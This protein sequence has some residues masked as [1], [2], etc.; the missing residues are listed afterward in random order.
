MITIISHRPVRTV[1]IVSYGIDSYE[2]K[3]GKKIYKVFGVI[4]PSMRG[5]LCSRDSEVVKD[6]Y[7]DETTI[8]IFRSENEADAIECKNA[9]DY[10]IFK[11]LPVFNVEGFK[12]LLEESKKEQKKIE[13]STPVEAEVVAD[14]N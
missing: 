6:F 10:T 13:E 2:D 12:Q 9:L 11:G 14:A 5:R 8:T 7:I 4:S 3:G 1:D